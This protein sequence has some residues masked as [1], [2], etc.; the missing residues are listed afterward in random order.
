MKTRE[1]KKLTLFVSIGVSLNAITCFFLN[2]KSGTTAKDPVLNAP[3]Q[4]NLNDITGCIT[5]PTSQSDSEINHTV[6]SEVGG[7]APTLG[8]TTPID[9]RRQH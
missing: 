3:R 8:N 9:R 5:R 1:K 7:A 6:R 2:G 4:Y